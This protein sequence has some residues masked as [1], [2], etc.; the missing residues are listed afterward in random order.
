MDGS[1]AYKISGVRGHFFG[2]SS[3]AT[4]ALATERNIVK[5]SSSLDLTILA[6]LSCGFQTGAGT[7]MNSLKIPKGA[8]L[9]VFG[10]GSAGIVAV[11]A[12]SQ[13]Y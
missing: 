12:P 6:P 5:V 11:M 1:N 2:Q 13:G 10:T 3:F 9:A 4:H 7:V 8:S